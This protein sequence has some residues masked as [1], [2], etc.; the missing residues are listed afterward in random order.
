MWFAP[1]DALV[2]DVES[3]NQLEGCPGCGPNRTRPRARGGR[4]NRRAHGFMTSCPDGS[5]V[6]APTP[7][8]PPA[9]GHS[10][11]RS[12]ILL[13][14]LVK[15]L[16]HVTPAFVTR[17][18]NSLIICGTSPIVNRFSSNHSPMNHGNTASEHRGSPLT[19][20]RG[21]YTWHLPSS[22]FDAKT[23]WLNNLL[24]SQSHNICRQSL[25]MRLRSLS[26]RTRI[27]RG[28]TNSTLSRTFDR[29][30]TVNPAPFATAAL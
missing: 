1:P 19:Y 7:T 20:L 12:K 9:W 22:T 2:L 25:D 17:L 6:A 5:R 24:Y 8:T 13:V 4:G 16:Q 3:C 29:A 30:I 11:V 21:C 10:G 18:H 27:E 23:S 15:D 28:V 26:S 14:H